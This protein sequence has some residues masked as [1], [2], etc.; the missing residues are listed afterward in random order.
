M[1][2]H[3]CTVLTGARVIDPAQ[4]IDRV[5]SVTI[6]DGKI[7]SVGDEPA[8]AGAAVIDLSGHCLTPGWVDIHVHAY[9]TLGFADPDSI[10]VYQGVTS[11]VEA[12][13]PGIGT[14]DECVAMT[15]NR[16]V[17]SLYLGPYLR[18]LGLIGLN[19]IEGDPRTLGNVP[20]DRWIDWAAANPGLLR[21][22][23]VIALG[24]GN[25]G[26]LTIGKGLAEILHLPLYSHIGEFQLLNPENPLAFEAFRVSGEGD[27]V[28]HLYHNNLGRI[29]DADGK[30]HPAVIDA[31]RRG[32]LFDIGFG[33]YNFSWDIAEKALAQG[34]MPH[35]ISSDLQQYNVLSPAISLANVMSVFLRLGFSLPEVVARVT[36]NAAKAIHLEDRAGSLR[37]GLPADISV[38]RV[39]AGAFELLDCFKKKRSADRRI[40]P[41]MAFKDGRRFDCDVTRCQDERNWFMQVAEDAVP[42][43][44]DRLS[45]AQLR[46]LSALAA[47]LATT[48]WS[49]P[50]GKEISLEKATELQDLFHRVRLEQSLP[51][52]DALLAVYNSFLENPFAMQIGLFLI[53]LDRGFAIER[54]KTVASRRPL[55]A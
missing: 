31:E 36:A 6:A 50:S 18:P 47:A 44:A 15:R 14:L 1:T 9:G 40:V 54:L 33:G 19:F 27:I 37:P 23:K 42:P 28:T 21:Y 43:A 53:R 17:T 16:I 35:I 38:F 8:P 34:V 55:A 51:L 32:V 2:G 22:V 25:R 46:F 5:T 49:L 11:F 20:I 10:G 26:P 29:I 41:V 7:L 12:G 4:N 45:G 48:D 30:V 52:A 13:G 24:Y 39:E 3:D